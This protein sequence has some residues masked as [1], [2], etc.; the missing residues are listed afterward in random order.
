MLC[1]LLL[2]IPS[3][4][5][6][7][8]GSLYGSHM[9]LQRESRVPIWGL[10]RAGSTVEVAASWGVRAKAK[11]DKSGYWRVDLKTGNASWGHTLT[12][13]SEGTKIVH[14]DIAFGEVWVCSGQS[15]M[16][17]WMANYPYP[18]PIPNWK[19]E[20]AAANYPEVRLFQVEKQSSPTPMKTCKGQW[21][22][23]TS[24][25]IANFSAAAYFFGRKLHQRLNVPVGLIHTSWGGTE[26]ELWASHEAMMRNREL[27]DSIKKYEGAG[28]RNTRVTEDWRKK[29]L[30]S[31]PGSAGN[32][33]QKDLD[34]S[35][36]EKMDSPLPWSK[37]G[38][39]NLDGI[40]Y[41]RARFDLT[42]DDLKQPVT[43]KLGAW[44]DEDITY[45]NGNQV[46]ATPEWNFLRNYTVPPAALQAGVNNITIRLTDTNQEG[47]WNGQDLF[48]EVA[49]RKV[50]FHDWR[51]RFA[52][53]F[54]KVEKPK[55]EPFAAHSVLYNGM[56]SP[57]IP[58]RIRGAIWYQGESNVGRAFQYRQSFPLMINDWRRAFE[59]K[60]MPFYFVQIAPYEYGNNLSPELRDAQAWVAKTLPNTGMI[61]T[62][63]LST[64]MRNIHPIQKREVGERLAGLALFQTYQQKDAVG[65]PEFKSLKIADGKVILTFTN[66]HGLRGTPN[67][68]QVAGKDQ[69]FHL[70]AATILEDKIVLTCDA[71]PVPVAARYAWTDTSVVSLWNS[72]GFPMA[73]FRTD[74]WPLRTRDAKW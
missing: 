17:M 63:D 61:S 64:D 25:S 5:A 42:A 19:E 16:E 67:G 51:R 34:E 46:G 65:G 54:A 18:S 28:E 23:C 36:W 14:N 50:Q 60:N 52:L 7:Q 73:Q 38:W 21:Q 37:T 40:A 29:L 12:Y 27:A 4:T 62:M 47:G 31:D 72:D 20:V 15:N 26:V 2:Q 22:A 11:A 53:D 57:L 24:A 58:Y 3:D 30:D 44:D 8:T 66:S 6:F 71:V 33:S 49:D 43:L 9:V 55:H 41:Y 39:D 13:E 48:V 35:E 1:L 56:I 59:S 32:W 70:A 45:V 69:V 68:F 74:N 10:S